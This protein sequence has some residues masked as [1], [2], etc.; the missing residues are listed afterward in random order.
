M[1]MLH[2]TNLVMQT[3]CD[4]HQTL[5]GVNEDAVSCVDTSAYHS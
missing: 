2:M 5:L 3:T 4:L 1:Y